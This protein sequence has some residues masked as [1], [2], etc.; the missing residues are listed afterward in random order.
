[1]GYRPLAVHIRPDQA[2]GPGPFAVPISVASSRT[3]LPVA[4]TVTVVPPPGW[5]A[6]PPE[7]PFKLA[8]GAHVT[9][10]T[11]I[12][13]ATDAPA[14]RYF[15]AARIEDESGQLHEDVITL[16]LVSTTREA[17]MASDGSA[18]LARALRRTRRREAEILGEPDRVAHPAGVDAVPALLGDELLVELLSPEV[19]VSAGA[20]GELRVRLLN[21][22]AGEIRGEAQLISPH[23]TWPITSPWTTGFRVG[24]GDAATLAFAI[25]PHSDFRAGAW[26]GL[27]KVMY[28]GRLYYT[29]AARIEVRSPR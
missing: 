12:S 17:T 16:D 10:E 28:F 29:E 13:P 23:D 20:R 11:S 5:S 27:V 4:G 19:I 2:S 7:R 15:A 26:W 9:F 1:M 3:D 6:D 14:G 24:P 21:T 22:V 25:E 18:A 8:P